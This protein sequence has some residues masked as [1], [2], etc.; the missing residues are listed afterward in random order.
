MRGLIWGLR[1]LIWDLRSHVRGGERGKNQR[2]RL[3]KLQPSRKWMI[4]NDKQNILALTLIWFFLAIKLFFFYILP[5]YFLPARHPCCIFFYP[6]CIALLPCYMESV[7]LAGTNR[8]MT[9]VSCLTKSCRPWGLSF[10]RLFVC[11]LVLFAT[12]PLNSLR[13]LNQP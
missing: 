3:R 11:L 4:N 1:E 12:L 7:P 13:L 9:N 8:W 2:C 10:L 6:C 5:P